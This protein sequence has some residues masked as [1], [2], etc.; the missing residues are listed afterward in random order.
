M[1]RHGPTGRIEE[2]VHFEHSNN[3]VRAIYSCIP[4]LSYSNT[5]IPWIELSLLVMLL[6][7]YLADLL[8]Q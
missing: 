7:S 1:A 3:I 4:I 2:E 8:F 5:N 6:R